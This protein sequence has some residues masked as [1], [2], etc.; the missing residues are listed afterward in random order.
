[1][2]RIYGVPRWLRVANRA[3]GRALERGRGPAF[4][5]LL[6]V[7]DRR[8][9]RPRTTPIAPLFGDGGTVWLVAVY[10]DTAWVRNVRATGEVELRRGD[11]RADYLAREL[12]AS[13]SAPVLR[14]YLAKPT[15]RLVRRRFDATPGSDDAV[16][17]A[18]ARRHPTFEL[19]P[20]GRS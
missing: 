10:G 20:V 6:T 9:G 14:A 12:D 8:T 15:S 17:A 4:L 1:M 19:V 5:R 11:D 2:T 16:L 7:V 18:E 3:L 13:N